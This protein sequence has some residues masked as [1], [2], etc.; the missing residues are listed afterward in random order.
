MVATTRALQDQVLKL[1]RAVQ[2]Y[3]ANTE[4]EE[5]KRVERISKMHLKALKADNE[6]AYMKL[7]DTVKDIHFT[8]PL[9]QTDSYLNS[10]AHRLL[11]RSRT[12]LYTRIHVLRA[13]CSMPFN[14]KSRF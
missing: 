10:L 3:H 7:I 11:S 12:T 8:R 14:V 2:T 4:K 13:H 1:G 9:H 5:A 6:E